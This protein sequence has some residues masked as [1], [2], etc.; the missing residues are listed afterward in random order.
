MGLPCCQLTTHK[1]AGYSL[2]RLACTT[3]STISRFFCKLLPEMR[4][5]LFTSLP[6]LLQWLYLTLCASNPPAEASQCHAVTEEASWYLR[7]QLPK[8]QGKND[9]KH[10]FAY[11]ESIPFCCLSPRCLTWPLLS[12]RY[13]NM[14]GWGECPWGKQDKI[15]MYPILLFQP[16]QLCPVVPQSML[17]PFPRRDFS[18]FLCCGL[19]I[20]LHWLLSVHPVL[21]FSILHLTEFRLLIWGKR[22]RFYTSVPSSWKQMAPGGLVVLT[23]FT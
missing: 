12:P 13:V 19:G 1:A 23:K 2:H 11:I 6:V 18:T 5:N 10:V 20:S 21:P 16:L 9:D 7:G 4:Q 8:K 22:L 15:H 14:L 17:S 3:A